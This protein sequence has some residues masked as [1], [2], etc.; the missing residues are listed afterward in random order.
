MNAFMEFLVSI[1]RSS[2]N[3][4]GVTRSLRPVELSECDSTSV[5][6]GYAEKCWVCV[7]TYYLTS[8]E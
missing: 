8:Y 7:L 4:P 6:E 1:P 5:K 2:R 3:L